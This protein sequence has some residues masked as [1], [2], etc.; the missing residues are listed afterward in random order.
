MFVFILRRKKQRRVHAANPGTSGAVSYNASPDVGRPFESEVHETHSVDLENHLSDPEM[1]QV[2][3][4]RASIPSIASGSTASRIRRVPVPPLLNDPFG[5]EARVSQFSFAEEPNPFKDPRPVSP[6]LKLGRLF[7]GNSLDSEGYTSGELT[8]KATQP[9]RLSAGSSLNAG[10]YASGQLTPRA[11]EHSRLSAGSS[12]AAQ[13][14]APSEAGTVSRG[15][16]VSLHLTLMMSLDW[17][18]SLTSIV[19]VLSPDIDSSLIED[20]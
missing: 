20:V 1:A 5:D 17:M 14:Y 19:H 2:D 16:H 6:D 3:D 4:D 7:T 11:I 18:R 9:S 10:D 15:I 8:P 13:D 12:L